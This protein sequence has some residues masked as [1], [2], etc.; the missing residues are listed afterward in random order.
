LPS[1]GVLGRYNCS[2]A[3]FARRETA[4]FDLAT[5]G[6]QTDIVLTRELTKRI[7]PL[8]IDSFQGTRQLGLR[9]RFAS[10]MR[11]FICEA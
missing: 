6:R 3:N 10:N 5:H 1:L 4:C 8:H 7:A 2:P 11:I 9:R